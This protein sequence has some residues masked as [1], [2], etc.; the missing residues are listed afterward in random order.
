[1]SPK[2]ESVTPA[3]ARITAGR[4]NCV[5]AATSQKIV[6]GMYWAAWE[7]QMLTSPLVPSPGT[8]SPTT[9]ATLV[10]SMANSKTRTA[11]PRP[12]EVGSVR[13]R[14]SAA[15]PP[16]AVTSSG[17]VGRK[18]RDI[19]RSGSGTACF[20]GLAPEHPPSVRS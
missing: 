3:A 12:A 6:T 15:C 18:R 7:I 5:I 20:R 2:A 11:V 10:R 17:Y 4:R 13:A 16:V 19:P 14:G 9:Y 1:V 8:S